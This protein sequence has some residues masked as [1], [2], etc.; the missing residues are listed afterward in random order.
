LGGL[1]SH[2]GSIRRDWKK[3]KAH[4]EII[5]ETGEK[6]I[7]RKKK[8]KRKEK[9]KKKKKKERV[10]KGGSVCQPTNSPHQR[11]F[12]GR[13]GSEKQAKKKRNSRRSL[14]VL[15]TMMSAKTRENQ[16]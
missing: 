6:L 14:F 5:K 13:G 4:R 11:S 7:K 2:E 3:S 10:L 16:T 12:L 9:K 8:E 15:K 1:V